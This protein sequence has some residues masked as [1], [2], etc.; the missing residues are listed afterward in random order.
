MT[1]ES[2]ER[3][4]RKVAWTAMFGVGLLRLL[5]LTWRVEFVND[6][7]VR[8]LRDRKQPFVYVLWHGQLLPLIWTHRGRNIAIM[9]SEHR[10]GEIIA[11]IA[12]AIGF[13]LVRGS[14]SR[15][16]ARALLS[17]SRELE[18]GFDVAVTVDGPR[19]PAG[20]VTPGALV[21][22]QRTSAPMVPTAASA[23]R[24]WR[25]RSWDRFMIPKPFARVVVAYG[26]PIVI[27]ASTP[28]DAA[29]HV[30]RVAAAIDQATESAIA[31][32][33]A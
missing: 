1:Q 21:I 13:R 29:E 17:A 32:R 23:S 28:R 11:R 3:G 5:S 31:G 14:T 26:D 18:S 16:A 33:R 9:V 8:A 27:H 30:E 10:D 12:R 20:V 24:A 7:V 15:G 22:S 2:S 25:L 19:G 4:E 6:H